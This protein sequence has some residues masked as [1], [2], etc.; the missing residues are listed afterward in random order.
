M[1]L[2]LPPG[3]RF[4]PTDVELV[5]Y[6][7][8]GKI[9]GRAFEWDPIAV[10][11]VYKVE[12]WDLPAFSA[13]KSDDQEWY[14]YY[15]RDRKYPNGSRNKRA[16]ESGYWK[17]T[18]KDRCIRLAKSIGMKKT[19]VYYKGRAPHGERTD[20]VMHEYRME[21][22]VY[23]NLK[24]QQLPYV[25]ARVFKKSGTGPKIGEQ[26]PHVE[27]KEVPLDPEEADAEL[28]VKPVEE[29][30]TIMQTLAEFMR[31]ETVQEFVQESLWKESII[32]SS[33]MLV[34]NPCDDGYLEMDDLTSA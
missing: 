2:Q 33:W 29:T 27:D 28:A 22:K 21:D 12:P 10:V 6:Y 18:G 30:G 25:L 34:G 23:E 20:W 15:A 3:F 31:E 9:N 13:L 8:K 7:L 17:S 11:D 1:A 4:H 16:T 5:A 19:L 14:F 24:A 26:Y 32:D